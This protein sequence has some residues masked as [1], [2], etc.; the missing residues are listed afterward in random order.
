MQAIHVSR[1]SQNLLILWVASPHGVALDRY[2]Q[3]LM[4]ILDALDSFLLCFRALYSM[5]AIGTARVSTW[6]TVPTVQVYIP[7]SDVSQTPPLL[8]T[9][10]FLFV[11]IEQLSTC[12]LAHGKGPFASYIIQEIGPRVIGIDLIAIS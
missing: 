7:F 5:E 4:C 11:F 6:L 9:C 12:T 8:S 10:T 3:H 2:A 1:V